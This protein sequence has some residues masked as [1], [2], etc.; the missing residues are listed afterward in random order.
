MGRPCK[1][2]GRSVQ[3]AEACRS[4]INY[5]KCKFFKSKVHYLG[6]M[7]GVDRVQLLPEKVEA[8]KK[9]FAPTNVDEL[10]QFLGITGYYRKFVPFYADI[11]T[12]LTKLL[13]EGT[14]FKW[15]EQCNSAFNMLKEELCKMPSLQ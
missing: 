7:V 6:Y 2:P 8:I 14:E 1:A 13:R 10:C 4:K 3:A 11:T 12:C 5:S 15:S 9:L